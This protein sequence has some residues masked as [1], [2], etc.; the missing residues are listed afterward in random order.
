[1]LI[2]GSV[3][4]FAFGS[5]LVTLLVTS[6]AR[7]DGERHDNLAAIII[8]HADL[9]EAPPIDRACVCDLMEYII[10]VNSPQTHRRPFTQAQQAEAMLARVGRANLLSLLERVQA[11]AA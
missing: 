4:Y 10:N 6:I 9:A 1:M 5:V 11:N 3:T 2:V 7:L 8:A